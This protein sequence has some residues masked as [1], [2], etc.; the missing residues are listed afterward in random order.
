M[1]FH[2]NDDVDRVAKD[3]SRDYLDGI[4]WVYR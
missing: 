4:A 2:A 3:A 1:R